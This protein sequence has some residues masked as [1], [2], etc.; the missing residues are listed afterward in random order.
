MNGNSCKNE[1]FENLIVSYI[2]DEATADER[3]RLETHILECT[4]CL[5]E[6]A[7]LSNARLSVFEWQQESFAKIETPVFALPDPPSPVRVS[8]FDRLVQ[9][10]GQLHTPAHAFGGLIVVLAASAVVSLVLMRGANAPIETAVVPA[11]QPAAQSVPTSEPVRSSEESTSVG[12]NR[13]TVATKEKPS[14]AAEPQIVRAAVRPRAAQ[15][16]RRLTA[17][18]EQPIR[19]SKGAGKAPVLSDFDDVDD[20]SL[21]L[22][23]LFDGEIG[24]IY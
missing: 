13:P 11:I 1:G 22:S 15:P 10:V 5:D 4:S 8:F 20:R 24:S 7:G 14:G 21:T 2:Y 3:R 23:D 12:E 6:F 19:R 17:K 18:V 9:L 16:N